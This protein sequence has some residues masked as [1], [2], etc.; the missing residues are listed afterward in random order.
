MPKPIPKSVVDRFTH[1][2][3]D[4]VQKRPNGCHVWVGARMAKGYG[5]F[6]FKGERY[7]A[8]RVA[9]TQSHGPIQHGMYVCHKC[10]RPYCV[11]PDHLFLGTHT[12]NMRDMATKGRGGK[13]SAKDVVNIFDRMANGEVCADIARS[14]NVSPA[15]ISC[16][17]SRRSFGCVEIAPDVLAKTRPK[18]YRPTLTSKGVQQIRRRLNEG[19][20]CSSIASSFGVSR[21]VVSAIKRNKTYK[22]LGE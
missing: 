13:L 16:V 20:S 14:Y 3:D 19:E 17:K 4:Y 12:D 8:H 5:V 2:I 21:V 15:T 1:L 18:R 11:N 22:N 9:Y 7:S 10:D 6:V